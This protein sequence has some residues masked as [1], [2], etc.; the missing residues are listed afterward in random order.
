MY[1]SFLWRP[2][3]VAQVERDS[4]Q[5]TIRPRHGRDQ[6]APHESEARDW[7]DTTRHDIS[8]HACHTNELK[9]VD[10]HL[11]LLKLVCRW[12]RHL[13]R[14][15]VDYENWVW[16]ENVKSLSCRCYVWL[17]D[18]WFLLFAVQKNGDNLSR[19]HPLSLTHCYH[20]S[21][22]ERC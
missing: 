15:K 10:W 16:H 4:E 5:M 6:M 12:C 8:V 9:L 21:W 22:I 18:R 19:S 1:E 3:V 14:A 20:E 7:H 17:E 11:T 2:R 13:Y